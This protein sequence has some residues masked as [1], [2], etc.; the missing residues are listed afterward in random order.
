MDFIDEKDSANL[1]EQLK[2]L[3][4]F[5]RLLDTSFRIPGTKTRFG[6]DFLIGLVPYA[7][8]VLSFLFSAGLIITMARH[9]V[10]GQVIGRMIWNVLLDTVVGSVPILGDIFDLYFKANRRNFHLLRDHYGEGKYT[11]SIWRVVIPVL[12]ALAIVFVLMLWLVYQIV[13]WS[14]GLMFG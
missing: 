2:G 6:I 11:G 4:N 13:A 10:S 5:T 7:G 8:D 12:I 9:G 1:P 14:W 3:D